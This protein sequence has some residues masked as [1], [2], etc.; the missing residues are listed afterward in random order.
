MIRIIMNSECELRDGAKRCRH[1][2]AE[3]TF[4]DAGT[5]DARRVPSPDGDGESWLV[6]TI[7]GRE[8]MIGQAE[9]AWRRWTEL[10]PSDRDFVAIEE[11]SDAVAPRA[12]ECATGAVA[13]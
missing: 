7:K 5:Y 13:A 11:T 8:T 6:L 4:V 12:L 10:P 2:E 3:Y 1:P 9:S